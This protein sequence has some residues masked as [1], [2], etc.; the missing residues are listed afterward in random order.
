LSLASGGGR[1]KV[2]LQKGMMEDGWG[3]AFRFSVNR[4]GPVL[5]A[6]HPL[7]SVRL[8]SHPVQRLDPLNPSAGAGAGPHRLNLRAPSPSSSPPL[9]RLDSRSRPYPISRQPESHT[10][11]TLIMRPSLRSPLTSL[12]RITAH[13]PSHPRIRTMAAST[14]QSSNRLR[15]VF[16]KNAGGASMGFWQMLPGANISRTLARTPGI[17]WILVD[18]EH[19]NIDGESPVARPWTLPEADPSRCCHAR[20]RPRHRRPECLP[21]RQAARHAAVDGQACVRAPECVA[22]PV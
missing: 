18:C 11:R 15:S 16:S 14:M 10:G 2:G 3:T 19:G 22:V 5:S 7:G 8:L 17:D 21:Y 9:P 12:R 13:H 1:L 6:S 20:C 4:V